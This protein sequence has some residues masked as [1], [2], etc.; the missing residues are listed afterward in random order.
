[1]K[2]LLA[3]AFAIVAE[4]FKNDFDK[5]GEPYIMHLLYVMSKQTTDIRKILALLHDLPEDK[6]EQWFDKLLEMGFYQPIVSKLRIL[7]RLNNEDYQNDYIK[8]IALD[9]DC[10]AVK[11]ADL[12]HNT[13]VSRLKG[14]R[15]KDFDRLEKYCVAYQYLKD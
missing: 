5:G 1:M 8:R 12:E 10:K 11:I 6:G 15:K 9:P 7:T 4:E 2:K 3:L 14:L 13:K